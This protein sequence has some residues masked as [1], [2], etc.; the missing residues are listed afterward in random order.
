M[1]DA[2]PGMS[3]PR[4]GGHGSAT[5]RGVGK[6]ILHVGPHKTGTTAIQKTLA[7]NRRAL[8]E[9]GYSYPKI[10]FSLFGHYK[11]FHALQ[12]SNAELPEMLAALNDAGGNIILSCEDFSRAP[13][14]SAAALARGLRVEEARVIYYA[15]NFL[16]LIYSWW[17]ERLKNGYRVGLPEFT[18]ELLA[19]PRRYHLFSPQLTL[20]HYAT[21]FGRPAIEIYLY[22]ELVAAKGT[23]EHFMKAVVG[24]AD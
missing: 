7:G 10:G 18:D 15:R 1:N 22:D 6:L 12:Q 23:V 3:E 13:R 11:L 4:G 16:D 21:L 24:L 2:A 9:H 17:Q 14:T 8:G 20:D 5:T 19:K